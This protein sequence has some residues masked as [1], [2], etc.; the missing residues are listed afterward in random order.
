MKTFSSIKKWLLNFVLIGSIVLPNFGD[1]AVK[2]KK[3]LRIG[4]AFPLTIN[5]REAAKNAINFEGGSIRLAS[6]L[7][8]INDIRKKYEFENITVEY[9]IRNSGDTYSEGALAA[10][11]LNSRVFGLKGLHGVVSVATSA[12]IIS[13]NDVAQLIYDSDKSILS[14]QNYIN[15]NAGRVIP[16]SSYQSLAIVQLLRTFNWHRVII[17]YS[18]DDY[19]IDAYNRLR[20]SLLEDG[21][22][23]VAKIGV[24]PELSTGAELD[25]LVDTIANLKKYEARIFVLLM[26]TI[27]EA[28]QIIMIGARVKLFNT[29]T[30]I[31]GTSKISVPRLLEYNTTNQNEI[32]QNLLYTAFRGYI[33]I[34]DAYTDWMVTDIGLNFTKRFREQPNT[35]TMVNG[36][37]VCNQ[38]TDDDGKFKLWNI[39]TKKYGTK[40]YFTLCAGSNYSYY[41]TGHGTGTIYPGH[42]AYTYDS[43]IALMEGIIGHC[44]KHYNDGDGY[45]GD[46]YIPDF[47]SGQE[48]I[49]YMVNNF[50]LTGITG[51]LRFAKGI[52]KLGD[53]GNGDRTYDV[54][55]QV[56]NFKSARKSLLHSDFKRVGTWMSEGGYEP[57]IGDPSL[58]SNLTGGCVR[59]SWGT[60]GDGAP[61]DRPDPI[62][63]T[64]PQHL[65]SLCSGL[66]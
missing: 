27:P 8:A 23:V 17:F 22:Q 36:E 6:F 30:S 1:A 18:S 14:H 65:S 46:F 55:Y 60:D 40:T 44:K 58:Q 25:D 63:Q 34:Q 7:M 38:D 48:V 62:V 52:E 35:V 66:F 61:S 42:A 54:R 50:S 29:D 16:A 3:I 37:A 2:R 21:V 5:V 26:E 57:C 19:G 56:V 59:I 11:D 53:Y 64:M 32:E 15:L 51:T 33:G 31:I 13:E 4:G 12:K 24:N 45:G 49:Q 20:L 39:T 47:L 41:A 28:K 10:I 9:A 43:A